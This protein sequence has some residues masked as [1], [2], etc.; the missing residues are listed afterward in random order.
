MVSLGCSF[1]KL[2]ELAPFGV[3]WALDWMVAMV[4]WPAY[5]RPVPPV[6]ASNLEPVII[7]NLHDPRTAYA[8]AQDLRL[9]FPTGYLVTW[10]GYGHGLKD[11]HIGPQGAHILRDYVKF[12]A[13]H[14]LPKYTNAVAKYACISKVFYY[15][16]TG[17][18]ILDGHTCL[19]PEPLKLGRAP[20]VSKVRDLIGWLS[21]RR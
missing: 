7:G 14:K 21:R 16:D 6:G 9:A 18:G 8:N 19:L 20:A 3:I 11:S 13:Q 15:L 2:Q 5:A 1:C 10:Q 4:T 17:E 12:M